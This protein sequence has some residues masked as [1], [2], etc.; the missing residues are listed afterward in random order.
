MPLLGEDNNALTWLIIINSTVFILLN[1]LKIVYFFS[2][3]PQIFFQH[4]IIDWF[5]LPASF[6]KLATRPWTVFTY[7][8]SHLGV[9][10][11]ISTLLWVW[12]F[13]YILQDLTGN[14][15]LIPIYLYG[16]VVGALF[17]LLTNNIFPVLAQ[18]VGNVSMMG[19][20]A[21]VMAVAV[22]TTTLAPDYRIFPLINGGIPLWVL[23]LVFVAID[24]ATV[25]SSSGGMA[26]AHLAGG[27]MGFIYIKQLGKG[28]DWGQWMYSFANWIDGLFNPEKKQA[29]TPQK[30]KLYYKSNQP[31]YT[32]T[33][34][35][36]QQKLDDILD[37]INQE[38]YHMLTD[39]EKLFLKK[40]SKEEF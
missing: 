22:G 17:F 37:K 33:P 6:E 4:Q 10:D 35:L 14:T 28:N 11:L 13:G 27:A 39:D 23:T 21:S 24:Y 34:N 36:T 32:K 38:G 25:A 9:M 2:D 29:A 40:A 30:D 3:I 8:F 5:C 7:M 31:P 1:F 18:N 15:K 19:A 20:G 12:G 16:G 26:V